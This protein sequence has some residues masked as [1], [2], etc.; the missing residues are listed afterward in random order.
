MMQKIHAWSEI[1]Q[2]EQI[3]RFENAV[4]VMT[5]MKPHVRARH[6]DMG[7]WGKRTKCGTIACAAG[8]CALDGWF[9][10]QG[11][12][13]KALDK[14]LGSLRFFGNDAH[15]SI[16]VS[17]ALIDLTGTKGHRAALKRMKT[18]LAYLKSIREV[19]GWS[20]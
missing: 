20:A 6:F 11:L 2:D 19:Q 10:K 8:H 12:T 9:R 15:N 3:E 13:L 17:S 14:D 4:R 18:Y 5:K 1:S 16:F 7:V